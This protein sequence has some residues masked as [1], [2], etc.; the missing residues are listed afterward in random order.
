MRLSFVTPDEDEIRKGVAALA[1]AIAE[2][3]GR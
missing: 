1:A 2:F 3:R